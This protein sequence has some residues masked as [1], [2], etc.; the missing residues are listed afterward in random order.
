VVGGLAAEAGSPAL[1]RNVGLR[2]GWRLSG[3]RPPRVPDKTGAYTRSPIPSRPP[4]DAPRSPVR[5]GSPRRRGVFHVLPSRIA[6]APHAR[7][8][9][10]PCTARAGNTTAFVVVFPRRT[11]PKQGLGLSPV[12]AGLVVRHGPRSYARTR[13]RTARHSP[14]KTVPRANKNHGASARISRAH[15]SAAGAIFFP[16][17]SPPASSHDRTSLRRRRPPRHPVARARSG[18]PLL[19]RT[20]SITYRAYDTAG[21]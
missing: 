19:L 8:P 6:A 5:T 17:R 21:W 18:R 10:S 15:P 11:R 14:H 2:P 13:R 1:A 4:S 7:Q 9:A 20:R 16:S 12:D 3:S